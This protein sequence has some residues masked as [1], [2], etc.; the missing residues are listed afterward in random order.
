MNC[1]F[2]V[3]EERMRDLQ[4]VM[5]CCSLLVIKAERRIKLV[6]KFGKWVWLVTVV[7][8]VRPCF[9]IVAAFFLMMI[10]T[11]VKLITHV[12]GLKMWNRLNLFHPGALLVR[13]LVKFCIFTSRHL[14]LTILS[15]Q[16]SLS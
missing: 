2:F 9:V 4:F 13:Y 15:T 8:I 11:F 12:D 3:G 7:T 6:L 1:L 14:I 5:F 10:I 16:Y